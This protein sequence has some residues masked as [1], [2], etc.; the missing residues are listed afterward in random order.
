MKIRFNNQIVT[1][2]IL[3]A[4]MGASAAAPGAF[5]QTPQPQPSQAQIT[6]SQSNPPTQIPAAQPAPSM[7][8]APGAAQASAPPHHVTKAHQIA[9]ANA[10]AQVREDRLE[11]RIK[12]LHDQL[13]ITSAQQ[14]EWDAL[15]QQMRDNEKATSNLIKTRVS[16]AGRM[17]AVDNLRSYEAIAQSHADG[18]QKLVPDF[19][20]LYNKLSDRQKKTADVLF[21]HRPNRTAART[22]PAKQHS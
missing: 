18:M 12:S 6:P 9:H 16:T 2:A 4:V 10:H 8:A 20:A 17:T 5:A 14:T 1:V 11:A 19:E 15:A 21:R 22:A 3:S 13:H 7:Q